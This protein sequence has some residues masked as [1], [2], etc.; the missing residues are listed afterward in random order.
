MGPSMAP[1]VPH[2]LHVL[3]VVAGS[4]SE[5]PD[6]VRKLNGENACTRV[7]EALVDVGGLLLSFVQ[8]YVVLAAHW[9]VHQVLEDQALFVRSDLDGNVAE[10]LCFDVV[11]PGGHQEMRPLRRL[12]PEKHAAGA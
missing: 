5:S 11:W 6:A 2:L 12:G 3:P 10:D 7:G 1:S 9:R 4:V 8:P